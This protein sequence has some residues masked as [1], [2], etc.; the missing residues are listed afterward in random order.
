[1]RI[2]TGVIVGLFCIWIYLRL[3]NPAPRSYQLR[4]NMTKNEVLTIMGQPYRV[5]ALSPKDAADRELW[6][7]AKEDLPE[8]V[9]QGDHLVSLSNRY[10]G[11]DDHPVNR[12][13][14]SSAAIR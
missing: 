7:Y 12:G 9:F 1:M 13:A 10:K 14:A 8:L 4:W 2:P 3:D 6:R 11:K 5:D